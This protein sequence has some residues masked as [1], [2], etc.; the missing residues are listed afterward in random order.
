MN[1][2]QFTIAH[3]RYFQVKAVDGVSFSI[4]PGEMVGAHY[5]LRPQTL[6]L[7]FL[8]TAG[9]LLEIILGG[10]TPEQIA[11]G[12]AIQTTRVAVFFALF[13]FTKRAAFRSASFPCGCAPS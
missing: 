1:H 10:L 9:A 12:L 3:R 4:E 8:A 5:D 2:V 11:L 13:Q 7:T 6:V